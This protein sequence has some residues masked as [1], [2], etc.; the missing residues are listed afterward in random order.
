MSGRGTHPLIRNLCNTV[1]AVPIYYAG[2]A[3]KINL[4]D[5]RPS[6]CSHKISV[7]FLNL[8]STF[9]T[10]HFNTCW[11]PWIVASKSFPNVNMHLT[12]CAHLHSHAWRGFWKCSM[13]QY[14]WVS[15][16]VEKEIH[17]W[18]KPPNPLFVDLLWTRETRHGHFLQ[19]WW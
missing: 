6:I 13:T 11:G 15:F 1:P 8:A 14:P 12:L 18:P 17:L 16:R 7:T 19:F 9:S 4:P 10:A 2:G 3:N 5:A